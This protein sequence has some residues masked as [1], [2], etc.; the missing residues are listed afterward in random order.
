MFAAMR[1]LIAWSV[2]ASMLLITSTVQA[3]DLD[4]AK[5]QGLVGEQINGYV[6]VVRNAPGIQALVNSVNMQRRQLYQDVAR[7]NGVPLGGVERLAGEKAISESTP[8]AMVQ[9]ANGAWMQK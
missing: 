4:T 5:S 1:S 2:L 7:R 3:F 8:G 6:G 9:D